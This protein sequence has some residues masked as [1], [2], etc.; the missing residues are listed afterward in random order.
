MNKSD[1]ID[2]I[3][4]KHDCSKVEAEKVIAMFTSSVTSALGDGEEISL[5]GF[6]NFAVSKVAARDGRNP[7][8]G[9]AI[10]IAAYNQ[11]KFKAGKGLKEAVN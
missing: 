4:D 11:P 9:D 7:R 10:K 3:A 1:F 8:T 2:Y 6:G 5:V